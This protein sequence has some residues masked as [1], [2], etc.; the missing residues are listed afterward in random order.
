M[1]VS[2][3]SLEKASGKKEKKSE[4]IVS[5]VTLEKAFKRNIDSRDKTNDFWQLL[6]FKISSFVHSTDSDSEGHDIL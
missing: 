1:T 3:V 6:V 5:W 4:L 2:W